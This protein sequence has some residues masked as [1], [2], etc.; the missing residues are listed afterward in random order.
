M[1]GARWGSRRT[2]PTK[3]G[4]AGKFRVFGSEVASARQLPRFDGCWASSRR[5]IDPS[6]R[7]PAWQGGLEMVSVLSGNDTQIASPNSVAA[8]GKSSSLD[9]DGGHLRTPDAVAVRKAR[10]GAA[11]RLRLQFLAAQ[12]HAL[13]PKLF[14]YRRSGARRRSTRG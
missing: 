9:A 4:T 5:R 7:N 13:G 1:P 3:V 11:K 2:L 10:P 14:H 6:K 8:Q 12:I